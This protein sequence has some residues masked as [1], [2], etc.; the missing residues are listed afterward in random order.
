M[1]ILQEKK[2]KSRKKQNK[3][4]E[5]GQNKTNIAEKQNVDRF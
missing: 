3:E 5:S 4:M 1:R 2:L